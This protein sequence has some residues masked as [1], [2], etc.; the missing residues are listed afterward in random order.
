MANWSIREYQPGF[1]RLV[2]A[3]PRF[4]F[5]DFE[6]IAE[7]L[8]S[9]LSA[10]VVEKQS[11]ADLHIWLIDFEGCRLLLKAEHYSESV[12]LETLSPHEG[13]DELVFI[14]QWIG[15]FHSNH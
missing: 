13:Q 9:L 7:Q 12:W 8:L 14:A 3:A 2:L 11:H 15:A 4:E 1:G 6:S 10:Q 5:D